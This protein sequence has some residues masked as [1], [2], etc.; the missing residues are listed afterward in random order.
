MYK[1]LKK[2]KY[3]KCVFCQHSTNK[4]PMPTCRRDDAGSSHLLCDASL[5]VFPCYRQL[6]LLGQSVFD[7]VHPCDQ[8]ELRDLLTP[9]TGGLDT[10]CG[11][12]SKV[13]CP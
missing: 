7:F 6:D 9:R 4:V 5:F 3:T 13:T 11:T 10:L 8:E 2:K 1:T 12:S